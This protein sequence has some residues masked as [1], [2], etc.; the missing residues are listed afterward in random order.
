MIIPI[1]PHTRT[2]WLLPQREARRYRETDG[3]R[4]QQYPQDYENRR[5]H[6][7]SS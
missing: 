3:E 6:A 1:G 2:L 4:A 5:N 7:G